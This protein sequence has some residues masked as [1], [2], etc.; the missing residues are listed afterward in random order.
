MNKRRKR[1]KTSPKDGS[2]LMKLKSY[3]KAENET[4]LKIN[5]WIR[6]RLK[7]HQVESIYE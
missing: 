5:K 2:R 4:S 3:D 6:V 1:H 7:V